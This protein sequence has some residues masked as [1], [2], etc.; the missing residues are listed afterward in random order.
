MTH[1]RLMTFEEKM[2]VNAQYLAL[3]NAGRH[4]EAMEIAKTRPLSP[5]LAL[6]WKKFLG[7]EALLQ[8][9][10]NLAEAEAKFGPDWLEK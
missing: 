3:D 5:E 9:G 2:A 10:W 4:E 1:G 8:S 7:K 6:V